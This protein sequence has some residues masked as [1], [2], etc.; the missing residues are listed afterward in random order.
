MRRALVLVSVLAAARAARADVTVN[1]QLTPAGE[2]LARQLGLTTAQLEQRI[3]ADV[4]GA[5]HASELDAFLTAVGDA[6]SFAAHG[7]GASYGGRVGDGIVGLG[8]AVS[9]AANDAL[10]GAPSITRGVRGDLAMMG[11]VNLGVVGHPRWTVYADG[12]Y[13]G[14]SS[15]AYSGDVASGGAHVQAELVGPQDTRDVLRWTGLALTGGLEVTRWELGAG[16]PI[17]TDLSLGGM[18]ATLSAGGRLHVV[19]T[20]IT[21]PLVVSTA[22]DIT[23]VFAL[24]VGGGADLD[25]GGTTLDAHLAGHVLS[26]GKDE[27]TVTIAG[28]ASHGGTPLVARVLAG[29]ELHLS[30]FQLVGQVDA[31]PGIAA[32]ALGARVAL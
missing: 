29:L 9:L 8:A 2:A 22:L 15:G 11:G 26:G 28:T 4:E 3:R 1:V 17:D 12:G 27:G 10:A 25:L 7:L 21:A 16:K 20:A 19:S 13:R 5:Y 30:R 32:A 14:L 24:Y 31:A 23:P 6:T 18:P